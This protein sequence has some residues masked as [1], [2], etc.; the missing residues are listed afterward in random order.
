MAGEGP[1]GARIFFVGEA[2]GRHED[3]T[4]R[5]FVGQAGK[6]L[7]GTLKSLG[8]SRGGVYI[9]SVNKCRPP[10]NRKPRVDEVAACRPYLSE[11]IDVVRPRIL[12][13]LGLHSL[14]TMTVHTG[15]MTKARRDEFVYHG[16]PLIAAYHPAAVLYNRQL[17]TKLRDDVSRAL[18]LVGKVR[19]RTGGIRPVMG[20]GY[21]V[22]ISSGG[23]PWDGGKRYLLI[24]R[25]DEG[26][27][28][29]PKGGVETGESLEEAAM[30]EIK[31][32][33]GLIGS[34]VCPIQSIHYRF[35]R[36]GSDVNITKTVHY[37]L[38][39]TRAGKPHLERCF[40]EYRWCTYTEGTRLLNYE[41]DRRV[42]LSAKRAV[43]GLS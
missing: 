24:K 33:T 10:A 6:V 15:G 32:E 19:P 31:E 12:V 36:P 42:L 17:Q 14:S 11:Q 30:R 8:I 4:G 5:P 22:R 9:T 40:E 34:I 39:R 35:Y 27:W 43:Q 28:G 3:L 2:P 13:A 16:I 29:F 20:K 38:V 41:N 23:V 25:M 37:Y 7:D 26:L 18:K 21:K 1:I